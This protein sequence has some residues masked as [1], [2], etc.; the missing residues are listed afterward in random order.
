MNDTAME[1]IVL[2]APIRVLIAEDHQLFRM[3]LAL[4]LSG[5][6]GVEVIGEAEDGKEAVQKVLNLKPD[7][8]IVDI[9]LPSIDGIEVTYQIKATLPATRVIVLTSHTEDEHISSALGASAD[10]YCLKDLPIEQLGKAISTVVNGG[11]WLDPRIADRVIRMSSAARVHKEASATASGSEEQVELS[12]GEKSLL[13]MVEQGLDNQEIAKT[14]SITA[15]EVGFLLKQMFERLFLSDRVRGAGK[16]LRRQVAAELSDRA[17]L[18]SDVESDEE[19]FAELGIGSIF[20][21]K[22]KIEALVGRGGVGRVYKA[23]HL[24]IDRM[25]AIKVLL[26]QFANDRKIVEQFNHE[27]KA[28]SV[29]DHPN[30]VMVYDFGV[31]LNGQPFIVMDYFEGR[32]L[33]DLLR[34]EKILD[35]D[36]FFEIF[37][38]VCDALAAAQSKGVVHCDL[39]PGNI[40]LE[41]NGNPQIRVKIVD[42]GMAQIVSGSETQEPHSELKEDPELAGSPFYM[43][44]EQCS[45]EPVDDRTDL[46]ALGCVMYEALTGEIAFGGNTAIECFNKHLLGKPQKFAEACPQMAYSMDLEQLVFRLVERE[47]ENRYQNALQLKAD[48]E[49]LKT[50]AHH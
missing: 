22:Y 5:I 25:V 14:L 12:E 26:P 4:L 32:P 49:K 19:P 18:A 8:A 7:V 42:F 3:G 21:D 36:R 45:G 48:L 43:S 2:P 20:A 29:L 27:A 10:A 46:Y 6:P 30:I 1:P 41:S 28:E 24:N 47:P 44:P 15:D 9:G 39:K 35:L 34:E 33:S 38:Q 23:K 13:V 50:I 16:M 37:T 11:T 31:T 17:L 40:L